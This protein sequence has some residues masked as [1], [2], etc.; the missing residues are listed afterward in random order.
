MIADSLRRVT[1]KEL[2]DPRGDVADRLWE[3]PAVVLAHGTEDDPLFFYGNRA[4]LDL[5]EVTAAELIR[6]PSRLS[7]EPVARDERARLLARVSADN[8]ISDYSG[9]RIA[10]SGKR[11]AIERATVWNLLTETGSIEGQA[12]CFADWK[13]LGSWPGRG[14]DGE[15]TYRPAR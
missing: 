12:A 10:K 9:V 5:F 14:S 8:F 3:L 1:G 13:V 7:A 2:V 11:F 15:R 6:M 4:A